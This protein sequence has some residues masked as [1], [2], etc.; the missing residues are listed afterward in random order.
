[1]P[2]CQKLD[3]SGN[4]QAQHASDIWVIPMQCFAKPAECS[5]PLLLLLFLGCKQSETIKH[6]K[7]PNPEVS[8]K[9]WQSKASTSVP[10]GASFWLVL[11]EIVA[12][13]CQLCGGEFLLVLNQSS[14]AECS[15]GHSSAATA[16]SAVT[17]FL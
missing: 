1:M 10:N 6:I 12:A 16:G 3:P 15:C 5:P 17:S 8:L 11:L 7:R 4:G 2:L 14:L 9:E 13:S